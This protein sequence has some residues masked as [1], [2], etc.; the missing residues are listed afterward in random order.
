MLCAALFEYD[1]VEMFF[2]GVQEENYYIV[3]CPRKIVQI[4]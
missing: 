2:E 3:Y 1:K 4:F